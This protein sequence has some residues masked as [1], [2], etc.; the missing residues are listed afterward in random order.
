MKKNVESNDHIT[1]HLLIKLADGSTML[2][3]RGERPLTVCLADA[4]FP[5]KI[6]DSLIGMAVG[7]K[8]TIQLNP[9][10][11]FGELKEDLVRKVPLENLPE[12]I[13]TG[14]ILTSEQDRRQWIVEELGERYAVLNG[15][16]P[17]AGQNLTFEVELL[18]INDKAACQC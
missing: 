7:E 5:Q 3:T 16:H 9:Q 11:G 15:N 12:E 1:I 2:D 4:G 14:Q 17:L 6:I 13:K 18:A 10:E 8:K